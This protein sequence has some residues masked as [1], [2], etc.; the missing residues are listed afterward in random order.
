MPQGYPRDRPR[1]YPSPGPTAPPQRAGRG[2]QS[3]HGPA[4]P[5]HLHR[6]GVRWQYRRSH[7]QVIVG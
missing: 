3:P 7:R 6:S 5:R 2:P 4:P 1:I